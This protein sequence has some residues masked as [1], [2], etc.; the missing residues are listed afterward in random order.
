MLARARGFSE[1]RILWRHA[2]RPS[3]LNLLTTIGLSA[4]ALIGGALVIEVLFAIPGIGRLM[5]N[6]VFLEDYSVV[7]ALVLVFTIGYVLI[8]FGVDLLYAVIDP[9]IRRKGA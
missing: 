6:S 2:F 3:S 8:N 4:G 1:R 7:Q 5:I 9:R